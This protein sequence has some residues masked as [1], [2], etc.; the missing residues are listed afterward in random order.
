[1]AWTVYLPRL[2]RPWT[3]FGEVFQAWS[4]FSASLKMVYCQGSI[5]THSIRENSGR[6]AQES[7]LG[8]RHSHLNRRT[9]IATTL[10]LTLWRWDVLEKLYWFWPFRCFLW[11]IGLTY[12]RSLTSVLKLIDDQGYVSN[13]K[14]ESAQLVAMSEDQLKFTSI[15]DSDHHVHLN[16]RLPF[17][18]NRRP[19]SYSDV[20]TLSPSSLEQHRLNSSFLWKCYSCE[21]DLSPYYWLYWRWILTALSEIHQHWNSL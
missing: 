10:P 21:C 12:F 8:N 3:N 18:P 5:T 7:N 9:P 17:T 20:I 16:D 15:D 13:F 11:V 6:H 19:I 2:F 4:T 1:M 14:V